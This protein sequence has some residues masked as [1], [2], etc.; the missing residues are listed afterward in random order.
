MLLIMS[1]L[2]P[3][4]SP[5]V[6]PPDDIWV[7]SPGGMILTEENWRTRRRTYPSA[8][9]STINPTW[10]VLGLSAVRAQQITTRAM[11]WPKYPHNLR[12]LLELTVTAVSAEVVVGSHCFNN[13]NQGHCCACYN[14]KWGHL[15]SIVAS[16]GT[17]VIVGMYCCSYDLRCHCCLWYHCWICYSL[18]CPSDINTH[19]MAWR[20]HLE[21]QYTSKMTPF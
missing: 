11:T 18:G 19:D 17:A 12:W 2:W 3:C 21:I 16:V 14:L 15:E 6:H 13:V 7:W 4:N 1:M 9:L 10:N 8:A 5:V 20:T